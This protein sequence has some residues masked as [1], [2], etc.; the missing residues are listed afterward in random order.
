MNDHHGSGIDTLETGLCRRDLFRRAG[1]TATGAM[2]LSMPKFLAGWVNEANAADLRTFTSGKV[3]LELEGQPAGFL[4]SVEGGNAFAEIVPE[5][6][7]P[8][9]I[10]RKRPGTVHYEDLIIGVPLSTDVAV[11]AAWIG[12]SLGKPPA[13]RSG[14]I[15]YTDFNMNVVK[16]LE[17]NGATLSEIT[18]PGADATNKTAPA[19]LLRLTPQNTRLVGGTGKPV[20]APLGAKQKMVLASNFRFTV[21]GFETACKRISRVSPL[22]TRRF[23]PPAVGEQRLPQVALGPWNCTPVSIFLPEV[24]AGPFYAWFEKT[25]MKGGTVDERA[26][27][28]EWMDPTFATVLASVQLGGLGIVRYAP[29]PFKPNVDTVALAQVDMY[30]ETM[31]LKF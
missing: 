13:L 20:Q 28:L 2:L 11:L 14:A 30:C 24:D 17:F 18:V 7:G 27:L 29:E 1:L 10:Q 31:N 22:N 12:E 3:L 15:L 4:S 6:L 25:V 16:R 5:T 8:E 26:G 21:P 9:G 23:Q 19:L